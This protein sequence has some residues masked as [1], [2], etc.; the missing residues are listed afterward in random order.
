MKICI[1]GGH[2][3]PALA[4][5]DGLP[6]G[7]DIIFIGRK[8]S[9][10]GDTTESLEYKTTTDRKIPF[11]ALQTGRVQR[12]LSAQ[13][14]PS[15]LK[16]PKGFFQALRILQ[17]E[18]PDIVMGFGGYLSFPVCM[19]AYMLRIPTVIHEQT[20]EAG[21][22]NK[23]IGTF[24]T[25]VCISF[26]TSEKF[27]P[28]NKTTLTGNPLRKEIIEVKKEKKQ[29]NALPLIFIT[30]GSTGSQAI[31]RVIADVLPS[32]LKKYTVVHQTGAAN[33][34][35]DG[36][37]LERIVASLPLDEKERYTYHHFLTPQHMAELLYQSDL[38]ISR[39]GMNTTT[40]LLYLEKRCIL[41]PLPHGQKM[42]QL[43]NARFLKKMGLAEI[44]DQES[45]IKDEFLEKIITMLT[46]E[47]SY[48]VKDKEVATV[49]EGAAAHI[50][51]VLNDVYSKKKTA[52]F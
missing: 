17:T 8:Y 43:E 32:L 25:R 51:Q 4:V 15:L 9:F 39:S 34:G 13:T 3:S 14:V 52:T 38:V 11:F 12:T 23:V 26:P 22:A 40:E 33:A 44:V 28:K 46:C 20:L 50:I 1:I 30:G 5:I 49:H 36:K 2:L 35:E 16:V 18:K 37:Y 6:E 41:I 21:L 42:E 45:I 27:F 31:N 47:T 24:A 19:A 48:T 29:K 7:T 10:E